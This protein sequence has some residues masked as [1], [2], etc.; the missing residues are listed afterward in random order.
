[1]AHDEPLWGLGIYSACNGL[2]VNTDVPLV[3]SEADRPDGCIDIG[4]DMLA[5]KR[6]VTAT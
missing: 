5:Q 3:L 4:L 6:V 1:M 2:S